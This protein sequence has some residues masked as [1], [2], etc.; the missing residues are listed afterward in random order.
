MAKS[1]IANTTA[2]LIPDV[3]REAFSSSKSLS[4]RDILLL[5]QAGVTF[6]AT[7]GK[8]S[9]R[10]MSVVCWLV[11][12]RASFLAALD[13]GD[14]DKAFCAWA[15]TF[16]PAHLV[17]CLAGI[18]D[19]LKRTFLPMEDAAGKKPGTGTPRHP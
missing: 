9:F 16:P 6:F 13:S 19:M 7:G 3:V 14:F 8:P 11:A 2:A 10:D 4:L 18:A 12:E 1:D 5:E 15:D 17:K